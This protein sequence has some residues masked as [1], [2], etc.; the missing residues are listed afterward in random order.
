MTTAPLPPGRGG[1][2]LLGETLAFAK[3]PFRFV[4]ERFRSIGPL[5]RCAA[6]CCYPAAVAPT[7]NAD[8]Y[9]G[10]PCGGVR[11]VVTDRE[12]VRPVWRHHG[13]P[14]FVPLV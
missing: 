12:T 6:P 5:G 8:R 2:P 7:P 1:L 4:E 14:A 11:V 10:L 3:N 9:Q 13:E